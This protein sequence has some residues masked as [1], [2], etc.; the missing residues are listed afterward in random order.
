MQVCLLLC[1]SL[2]ICLRVDLALIGGMMSSKGLMRGALGLVHCHALRL[3]LTLACI[4]C[5]LQSGITVHLSAACKGLLQGRA[6]GGG[7]IR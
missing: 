4:V 6:P 3:T 2:I 1:H 5:L 7:S